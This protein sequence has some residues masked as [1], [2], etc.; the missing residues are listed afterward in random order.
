MAALRKAIE[1]PQRPSSPENRSPAKVSSIMISKKLPPETGG[2]K[3]KLDSNPSMRNINTVNLNIN[4]KALKSPKEISPLKKITFSSDFYNMPLKESQREANNG[5]LFSVFVSPGIS[6]LKDFHPIAK[7]FKTD[8]SQSH[9]RVLL[10]P[11]PASNRKLR[12]LGSS[13]ELAK[14]TYINESRPALPVLFDPRVMSHTSLQH[15][16]KH[17]RNNTQIPPDRLEWA[18]NQADKYFFKKSSAGKDAEKLRQSKKI[19]II[20][21][22][23]YMAELRK[24]QEADSSSKIKDESLERVTT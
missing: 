20:Q 22:K 9:Y 12:E 1:Q 6:P 7:P 21:K 15:F 3:V 14:S 5:Q 2:V 11:K 10:K 18:N 4:T 19:E 24:K 17:R 16:K 8:S 23:M 13:R